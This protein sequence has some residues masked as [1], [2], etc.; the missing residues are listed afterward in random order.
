[1]A[2]GHIITDGFWKHI[3]HTCTQM[4]NYAHTCKGRNQRKS[5]NKWYITYGLLAKGLYVH[6]HTHTHKHTCREIEGNMPINYVY[7]NCSLRWNFRV[8]ISSLKR[9]RR[10]GWEREKAKEAIRYWIPCLSKV[11]LQYLIS[12][13]QFS[14]QGHTRLSIS[15]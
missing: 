5:V 9:K 8:V 12:I 6:A 11:N 15:C 1:M 2:I 4:H 13:K 7:Q 14:F 10:R 3:P